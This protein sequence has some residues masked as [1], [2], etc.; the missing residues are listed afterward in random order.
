MRGKHRAQA[1]LDDEIME[2]AVLGAFNSIEE[3]VEP[4]SV[5]A[6]NQSYE[7]IFKCG[8]KRCPV[9]QSYRSVVALQKLE[10]IPCPG[11]TAV[12]LQHGNDLIG[13]CPRFRL[14]YGP[15]PLLGRKADN[16]KDVRA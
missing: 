3:Y 5:F 6:G 9:L 11:K 8:R 13:N 14:I 2:L 12:P 16:D 7:Q 10:K 4:A 1:H 15:L